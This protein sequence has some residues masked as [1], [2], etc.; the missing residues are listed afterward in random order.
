MDEAVGQDRHVGDAGRILSAAARASR[1][2]LRH[3]ATNSQKATLSDGAFTIFELDW[4]KP[5]R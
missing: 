5:S 1:Q 4:P 3:T 2:P